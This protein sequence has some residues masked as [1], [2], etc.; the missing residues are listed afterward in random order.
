MMTAINY[1]IHAMTID[2]Y[3]KII[4]LLRNTE[5]VVLSETDEREPMGR[6]LDRVSSTIIIALVKGRYY[7]V[8]HLFT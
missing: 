2:D 1:S 3:D 8:Q 7:K 6:F 4:E 5:N